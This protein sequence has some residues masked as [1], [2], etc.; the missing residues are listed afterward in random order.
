MGAGQR[1]AQLQRAIGP[2]KGWALGQLA[3]IGAILTAG[4]RERRRGRGFRGGALLTV[5]ACVLAVVAALVALRAKADLGHNLT[6]SPTPV[7]DGE[8]TQTGVYGVVRHPMYLS[9][10]LLLLA[11]ALALGSWLTLL[12]AGGMF[13]FFMLKASHEE[14]LLTRRY[15]GYAAYAQR[16]CGRSVPRPR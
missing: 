3:L 13:G 11:A 12:G 6:M 16:V 1:R 7:H 8:L 9:V 14:Q 2:D 15:P 4:A 5:L 10:E